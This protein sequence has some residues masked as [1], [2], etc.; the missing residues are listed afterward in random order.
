MI[1]LHTA[2]DLH[3]SSS[4]AFTLY[5]KSAFGEK[6]STHIS[7]V[8]VEVLYLYETQKLTTNKTKQQLLTLLKKQDKQLEQNY[9]V[10][11]NLRAK[12][13][14]LKPGFKF[15]VPFLMYERGTKPGQAH[16]PWMVVILETTKKMNWEDFAAK[17]RIAHTTKKHL[18]L[19][20]LSPNTISYYESAWKKLT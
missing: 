12:G 7:Y 8:P 20:L 5:E 14:V 3:S 16:A 11:Q 9:R 18:M 17:Q 6:Q 13:Y 1:T 2:P 15:G 19:A 10:Y 4:D